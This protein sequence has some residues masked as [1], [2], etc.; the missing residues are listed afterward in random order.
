MPKTG[1]L[2]QKKF[3]K[4][5]LKSGNKKE[6]AIVAGYSPKTAHVTGSQ[7]LKNPNIKE[8]IDIVLDK[9]GL[10]DEQLAT[11]LQ[12]AI[13]KGLTSD[14]AT[15]SDALRG[16]E[17]A[18]RLKDKFPST[19]LDINKKTLTMSLEGKSIE[20]L[21]DKYNQLLQEAKELKQLE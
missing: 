17:Q 8:K 10:T 19:R 5:Y 3:I 21:E 18:F 20:E 11:N 4:H 13:Q 2:K 9:A 15:V 16:I 7:L 6:S 1:T 12:E 14:K